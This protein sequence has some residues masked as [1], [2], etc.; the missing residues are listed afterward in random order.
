MKLPQLKMYT[1]EPAPQPTP[2]DDNDPTPHIPL[3]P[4]APVRKLYSATTRGFYST[5]VHAA[6]HLPQDAVEI[7]HE[8]WQGLLK[9][10]STGKVIR[11]DPSGWPYA[12]EKNHEERAAAILS[13]RDN[14]LAQTDWL[15]AR[16]RDEIEVGAATLPADHYRA[17]QSYR[18]ALR[19]L[20]SVAGFPD[21][22]LPTKPDWLELK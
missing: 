10:E 4:R 16:H 21:V 7:H 6:E 22:A 2:G 14:L 12:D 15:V 8:D 9:A 13:H 11:T 19:A 5:D 18:K 1:D 17:L 3:P 20:P